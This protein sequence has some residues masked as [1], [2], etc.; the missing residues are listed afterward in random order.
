[1]GI[2]LKNNAVGYLASAIGP[3]DTGLSL[4]SGDGANFPALGVGDYFYATLVSTSGIKE[5][6]KVTARSSDSM[7]IDRA[8]EGTSAAAF[9]AGD[10]LELRVTSQN[11]I[12]AAAG[13]A[14]ENVLDTPNTWAADQTFDASINILSGEYVRLY[15]ST[16]TTYHEI[17]N[18]SNVLTLKYGITT[19]ATI[20]A[21]GIVNFVNSPTI[22]GS[23]VYRD[24]GVDVPVVDGG[25]G[26]STA[27]GARTNLGLVIGTDVQA[28]N[29]FLTSVAALTHTADKL[30]YT[31]GA[32]TASLTD[33]TSF[34]RSLLDDADAATARTTLGLGTLSTQAAS[35]VAITGGTITGVTSLQARE[36]LSAESTGTLTA[37]SANATVVMT[38]DVTLDGAVFS[39]GDIIQFYSGASSRTVT[40]GSSM[41]LRLGGSATTGSRTL[42]ART[43]AT[44]F[45][46]GANE[47]VITGVGVS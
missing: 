29:A 41:T 35:S 17:S 39:Q 12:D 47:I 22:N 26:A 46:I 42:A 28:Y 40:Q 1:M 13:A 2:K 8:E 25:T 30:T 16:D 3:A 14:F 43:F 27:S 36:T 38:G 20:S 44:A 18:I 45:V 23:Y 21:A 34:A 19:Y 7:T 11:L 33:F 32:N 6:V 15:D 9:A 31:S 24:G 37:L 5:I 10:A 4:D